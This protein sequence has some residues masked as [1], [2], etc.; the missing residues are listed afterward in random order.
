MEEV[1]DPVTGE[2]TL[3]PVVVVGPSDPLVVEA[4]EGAQPCE[5]EEEE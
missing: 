3:E 2:I 5:E 4:V 1:V